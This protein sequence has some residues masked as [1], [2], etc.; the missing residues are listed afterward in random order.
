MDANNVVYLWDDIACPANA[1]WLQVAAWQVGASERSE[2]LS[3]DVRMVGQVDFKAS[4]LGAI[5]DH[6]E[7]E[8]PLV[9]AQFRLALCRPTAY[10]EWAVI[11][12]VCRARLRE[13]VVNRT[14]RATLGPMFPI[15]GD[16]LHLHHSIFERNV[17]ERRWT[18]P[19]HRQAEVAQILHGY[20]MVPVP[21]H[22]EDSL[23]GE[24]L[25][26][27]VDFYGVALENALVDVK[28]K[29][30]HL[31][32]ADN[33]GQSVSVHAVLKDHPRLGVEPLRKYMVKSTT[34]D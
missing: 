7:T 27:P 10:P 33:D 4:A 13:V 16:H 30:F 28:F 8:H 17:S 29:V 1:Q 11:W 18:I 2:W 25:Y 12:D 20:R 6:E 26:V 31:R 15:S 24:S 32:S 21:V 3:E 9:A 14:C 23:S 22:I 34:V 5:G 19:P